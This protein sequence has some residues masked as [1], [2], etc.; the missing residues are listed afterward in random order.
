MS[1]AFASRSLLE[2]WVFIVL[3]AHSAA[4]PILRGNDFLPQ[5]IYAVIALILF[6]LLVKGESRSSIYFQI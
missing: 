2:V 5:L 6:T 1:L 4:E 3:F